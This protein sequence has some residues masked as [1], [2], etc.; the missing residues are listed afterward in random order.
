M[1]GIGMHD[2][3][4]ISEE[5]LARARRAGINP[6]RLDLLVARARQEVQ[7]GRLPAVQLAVARDGAV[8]FSLAL[9]TAGPASLFSVFSATK[10][11]T[12]AAAW[13]L[14]QEGSLDLR[15]RVVDLIP[16]FAS[17]G[18]ESVRVE[19]LFTHTA[20]FPHAP[21]RPLDW[22]DPERRR[23]RWQQ[24]RLSWPP[25]SR[26]EYHPTATMWV[27][28]E[29]IE[30]LSGRAFIQFVREHVMVPLGLQDLFLGLPEAE[31]GRV[32]ACLPAGEP[33]T[34][35]DYQRL[36]LPVPPETE[37]TEA[38][39]LSFNDPK[40]RAVGLPGGGAITTA[41]DLAVFWQALLHGGLGTVTLWT[42]DTLRRVREV[43]TGTLMDPLYGKLANRG[44]GV[45]VAGDEART[46]RGFGHT[47]SPLAIGHNGAGGQ[48]A[49]ADPVTGLSFAYVT[50]GHDRNAVREARRSVALS[51]L[52]AVLTDPAPP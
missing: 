6:A 35:A 49:W 44:L 22:L 13:L 46:Y 5:A 10:A 7:T 12:A 41:A 37:V 26:Y 33:L 27:I 21:F 52:A 3:P 32:L 15:M 17:H 28:A 34:A 30:R 38:A 47:N 9:G 48:I 18:K 1:W 23:G 14:V 51:S 31:N 4:G 45:V 42:A 43:R 36:A 25:G 20:G 50:S 16:E 2:D 29:L 40:I 39:I 24:W 19:H 8:A 11:V